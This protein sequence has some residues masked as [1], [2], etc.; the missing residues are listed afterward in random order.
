MKIKDIT[1]EELGK[2]SLSTLQRLSS[3]IR[4][5]INR[6]AFTIRQEKK[7]KKGQSED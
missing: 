4:R 2:Q 3:K 5:T 6:K 1:E 7:N